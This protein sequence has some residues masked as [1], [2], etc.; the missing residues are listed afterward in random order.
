[1]NLINF[2]ADH[3]KLIARIFAIFERI[4]KNAIVRQQ[5]M[6]ERKELGE[7]GDSQLND[8]GRDWVEA[9]RESSRNYFDVPEHRL[10][11]DDDT[12]P[13]EKNYQHHGQQVCQCGSAHI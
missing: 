13:I 4:Q 1:M 3:S 7:M 9:R 5:V 2:A 6:Q 10:V 8:I 11:L 12:L